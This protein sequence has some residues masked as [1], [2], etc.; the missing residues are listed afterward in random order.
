MTPIER[1][2]TEER[3]EQIAEAALRIISNQ[4]VRRLTA[5]A[6]A[7]EVGIADGTIF[8]H[9]KDKEAIV[10][11]AI[12]LFEASLEDC[13]PAPSDEPLERLG[14]FLMKRVARVRKHPEILR[15]A[16]SDRLA[17]AA[18]EAG[19]A[20]VEQLVAR[21]VVFVQDC[22]A[23]AQRKGLITRDTPVMLLTWMVIGV[24]RGVSV[25]GATQIRGAKSLSTA[26]PR[27]IW[28]DLERCLRQTGP[29]VME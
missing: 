10:D 2:P 24:V 11:A 4:G 20:R 12:D 3:Q 6:L 15:L 25:P 8:R 7:A 21:S 18:G 19:A 9:F 1:L 27:K 5:A 23:A 28:M 22:L 26:S 16:F 14:A 17:E 13:Y 29:E